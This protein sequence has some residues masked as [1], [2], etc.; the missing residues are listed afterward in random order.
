MIH[1]YATFIKAVNL[2]TDYLILNISMVISYAVIDKSSYIW[3]NNKNYLP[4]VL[5][6]NLIWLFA[7]PVEAD[8][9]RHQEK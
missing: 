7:W 6:F 9:P 1:R 8:L 3:I 5:V 2:T 4:I